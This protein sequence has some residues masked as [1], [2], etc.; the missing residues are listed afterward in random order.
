MT[1]STDLTFPD[2]VGAMNRMMEKKA[3]V[4][5]CHSNRASEIGDDCIRKLV[6]ARTNWREKEKPSLALQYIFDL[7]N[8]LERP[9]V[10]KILDSGYELI[11]QQEPFEYK[12]NGETLLTGH[13]DG[14]LVDKDGTEYVLEI[15]T[16]K[17]NIWN[18][19]STES[20]MDKKPWT[21]KYSPQLHMYMLGLEIPRAIW[22]TINKSTG[23]PKQI[24]T[25]LDYSICETVLTR[26]KS[27][28]GHVK[29]GTLPDQL[30]PTPE[31]AAICE[32][33]PFR[34]LC[35]PAM[36]YGELKLIIDKKLMEQINEMQDL[37][38]GWRR[39]EKL[40]KTLKEKFDATGTVNAAIGNWWFRKKR[41]WAKCWTRME[42]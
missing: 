6:Y 33:C 29:N 13:I 11:R 23:E 9:T 19:I 34:V 31:Y 30:E 8:I 15:K 32:K 3:R 27:I 40:K 18:G 1:V 28:N 37:E 12:A 2:I 20:E 21:R 42:A 7:G 16:M 10:N 14:I 25:E 41:E 36:N 5:P 35:A 17:E 24:N 39:Y 38:D 4:Y 26:C 22:I